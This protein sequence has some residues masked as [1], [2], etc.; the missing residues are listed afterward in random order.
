MRTVN[1]ILRLLVALPAFFYGTA[2]L[3]AVDITPT[4]NGVYDP[5]K[6]L[7]TVWLDWDVGQSPAILTIGP[8]TL[9]AT[10][11]GKVDDV[12]VGGIPVGSGAG[13]GGSDPL[14]A[15][16]LDGLIPLK[17]EVSAVQFV[18]ADLIF[19][20]GKMYS[21]QLP[22]FLDVQPFKKIEA[23]FFS[24]N[25]TNVFPSIDSIRGFEVPN[26]S[27]LG[28]KIGSSVA[29]ETG[30]SCRWAEEWY[31]EPNPFAEIFNIFVPSEFE[32]TRLEIHTQSIPVPPAIWLLGSALLGLVAV[33]RIRNTA[34]SLAPAV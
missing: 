17:I 4:V 23:V 18:I 30:E 31:M 12:L 21:I 26:Q 24:E 2:A 10:F 11:Q 28:E 20:L 9:D 33:G 5:N 13:F 29:C 7:N 8:S 22:N 34:D 25:D 32:L 15:D 6:G 16:P 3:A 27:F 19:D 14:N 1:E